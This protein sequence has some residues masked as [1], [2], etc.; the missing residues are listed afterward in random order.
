MVHIANIMLCF[1][2]CSTFSLLGNENKTSH[3]KLETEVNIT[4]KTTPALCK[5][6]YL[7][8][9]PIFQLSLKHLPKSIQLIWRKWHIGHFALHNFR[10]NNNSITVQKS[11]Y[12]LTT[13][14][15]SSTVF[16][17]LLVFYRTQL[18]SQSK[19]IFFPLN[20]IFQIFCHHEKTAIPQRSWK[21]YYHRGQN[22]VQREKPP[23]H[24]PETS[25]AQIPKYPEWFT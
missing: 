10:S 25:T 15:F 8:F 1:L 12:L 5:V 24:T 2:P 16:S 14:L 6:W 21:G 9:K 19:K 17:T 7:G 13:T 23:L 22:I 4:H 11:M 3:E 20:L 18:D